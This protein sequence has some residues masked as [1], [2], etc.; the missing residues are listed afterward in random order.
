MKGGKQLIGFMQGRLCEQVDGKIQT[1]PWRDWEN[2]FLV[3]A[4]IGIAAMEWTLDQDRLYE[5]PIMNAAGQSRILALCQQYRLEIPS[6]TGDC[7]MQAPFWKSSGADSVCL[8]NDF[9][10]VVKAAS[11]I[12]VSMIV[13]PLV[14]NGRIENPQQEKRILG[15]LKENSTIFESC[16]MKILF[17]S[18]FEPINVARFIDCLDP[19]IFG[20]NYDI[21]NSAALG[22][23]CKE[24]IEEYGA[25]IDNVHI[26]DRFF[27]GTTVPIGRGNANFSQV[28]KSLKE[29]SYKGNFILQTA[30]ATDGDHVGAIVKY[31][32]M[33]ESW[34]LQY[35]F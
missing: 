14:D 35:G 33:V 30:R 16:H 6:L 12:G 21:G 5:N 8:S 4:E 20:I 34:M 3:A 2:E 10:N 9:V 31:R 28:F 27:G 23:N 26:K 7:F 13:V 24:E 17:E 25:R 1:F 19:K 15:F 32:N 29:K 22:F 11:S 18:D